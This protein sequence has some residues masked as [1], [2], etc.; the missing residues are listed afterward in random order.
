MDAVSELGGCPQLVRGDM[1]TENGHLA[2]MQTLLSGEE[3]FLYG[4]SMHNQRIES[5]W[6]IL[7]KEC[8]QFW[9]DTL[10]TLK[11]HGDFTG[12]AI[13]TSLIQFCFSTLVQRDLDNIASVWNTHTIRPSKNQNVPHGRPAV[14]FSMPEV[15]RPG[16][17]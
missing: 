5:F 16:I 10:R 7:R 17:T 9:M 1:G 3:S 11:D 13:D 2:R 8:S 14:L 6:C 15:F 12:D 4:A